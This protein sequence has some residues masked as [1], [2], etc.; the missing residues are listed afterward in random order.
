MGNRILCLRWIYTIS[1]SLGLWLVIATQTHGAGFY[2]PDTGSRAMSRGGAYVASGEGLDSLWHNPANLS[3]LT[4]LHFLY[5]NTLFFSQYSFERAPYSETAKPFPVVYNVSPPYYI[6]LLGISYDFG[7]LKLPKAHR[8]VLAFGGWGPN[9]ALYNWNAEGENKP[10]QPDCA[11]PNKDKFLCSEYG[12]QRYS[13]IKHTPF[14]LFFAW[15]LAYRIDLEH[16]KIRLGGSFQLA[17]TRFTQTLAAKAISESTRSELFDTI[18]TLDVATPFVPTGNVGITVDLPQGFAVGF[19]FQAPFPA[20]AS[21][22]LKV[23]KLPRGFGDAV[24]VE[25]DA[26]QLDINMP[27]VMRTGLLYRPPFFPR[28]EIEFAFVYEAWSSVDKIVL[29]SPEGPNQIKFTLPLFGSQALEPVNIVRNWQDT[30][31]IRAGLQFAIMPQHLFLRAG[32]FY[33]TTATPPERHNVTSAHNERHAITA[34]LEGR[35]PAGPVSL[36]LTFAYNHTFG[37]PLDVTN[38]QE[39]AVVLAGSQAEKDKADIVGNGKY[40]IQNNLVSFSLSVVWGGYEQ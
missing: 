13:V 16:V 3:R 7:F 20:N 5:D 2:A 23:D 35:I 37:I 32:W 39:R 1:V 24:K 31:S 21:G 17:Q 8:L 6:P 22:T 10:S 28:L 40:L 33:E 38:S 15:A 30:W 29:S 4:G 25:G 14:L 12:P 11:G 18:F 34:G 26:A 9:D 19:S 36:I 27:W